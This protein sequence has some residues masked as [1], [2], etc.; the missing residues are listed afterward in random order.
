MAENQ[1]QYYDHMTLPGKGPVY[2]RDA[3][4]LKGKDFSVS[5]DIEADPVKFDGTGNVD[6]VARIGEGVVDLPNMSETAVTSTLDDLPPGDPRLPT[7]GAVL[8]KIG[9]L[10]VCTPIP[11]ADIDALFP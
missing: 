7:A 1:A 3:K 8:D 5:G 10:P 9:D 6:L 11:D 2:F 4:L